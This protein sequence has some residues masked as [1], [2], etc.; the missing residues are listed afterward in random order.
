MEVAQ[1]ACLGLQHASWDLQQSGVAEAPTVKT[2]RAAKVIMI[3][4]NI[5]FPFVWTCFRSV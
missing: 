2:A 3:L 5:V 4:R 1:Q